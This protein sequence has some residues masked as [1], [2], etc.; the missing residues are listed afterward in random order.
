MTPLTQQISAKGHH[1]SLLSVIVDGTV[2][3][4]EYPQF[5]LGKGTFA[6]EISLVFG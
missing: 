5:I 2:F 6:A 4:C 3:Q 1:I